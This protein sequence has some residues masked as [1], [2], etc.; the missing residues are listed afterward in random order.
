[1]SQ[2]TYRVQS[3]C[4]NCAHVFRMVEYDEGDSYYCTLG[5]PPRPKCGSIAMGE[6]VMP[7]GGKAYM[8]ENRAWDDW[9]DNREVDPSGTCDN[10]T[11]GAK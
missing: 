3:G 8:A 4:H 5:A 1:M 11:G 10:W 7:I 6:C 2:P 9:S